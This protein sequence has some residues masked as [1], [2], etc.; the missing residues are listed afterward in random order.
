MSTNV[1]KQTNVEKPTCKLTGTDG[2][3]FA[4]AGL[5]SKALRQ[6]GQSDKAKEFT[7]KL[8]KTGSYDE[9]LTLMREYVEVE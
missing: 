2:N 9:A 5:V 8:F 1:E 7:A 4:L 6:A 3:V